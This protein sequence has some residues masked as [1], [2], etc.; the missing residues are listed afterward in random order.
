[1]HELA[2]GFEVVVEDEVVRIPYR[3]YNPPLTGRA[4]HELTAEERSILHCLYTRHHDGHVRQTNAQELLG[5]DHPW[6][7]PFVVKLI[8]E[9]VVEIVDVIRNW[10][11][12]AFD[13]QSASCDT[14]RRFASANPT[15]IQATAQRATSYWNCYYRS[16]YPNRAEYPAFRALRYLEAAAHS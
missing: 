1:M 3:I 14:Y 15:F 12:S 8:G 2:Q 6:V 11:E 13:A 4:L 10:L 5:H 9:Y 7:A 16:T